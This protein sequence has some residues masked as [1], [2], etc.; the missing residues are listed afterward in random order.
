MVL[1]F[2]H[3]LA[4]RIAA[5]VWPRQPSAGGPTVRGR[6]GLALFLSALA[7]AAGAV[8]FTF[9]ARTLG[10]RYGFNLDISAIVNDQSLGAILQ[11]GFRF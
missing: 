3:L 5:S 2:A 7:Q 6:V 8:S 11:A 9:D 10:L 4:A 1:K